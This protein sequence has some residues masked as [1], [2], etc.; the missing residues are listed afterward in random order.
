MG[1]GAVNFVIPILQSSTLRIYDKLSFVFISLV[2][3]SSPKENDKP[4][5]P[6]EV[7]KECQ[8]ES[9]FESLAPTLRKCACATFVT[10]NIFVLARLGFLVEKVTVTEA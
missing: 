5:D 7:N 9:C 4:V 10:H 6:H 3:N 1:K 2:N 8:D